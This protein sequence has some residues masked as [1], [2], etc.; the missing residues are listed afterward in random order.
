MSYESSLKGSAA[1][2]HPTRVASAREKLLTD[3]NLPD[4][5]VRSVIEASWQ[6]CVT[7]QVDP[8]VAKHSLELSSDE[9]MGIRRQHKELISASEIIMRE[10]KELLAL[11]S[12]REQHEDSFESARGLDKP[13]HT[14]VWL[15][16][17]P[18]QNEGHDN[19][20]ADGTEHEWHPLDLH[21]RKAAKDIG[22]SCVAIY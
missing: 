18:Q 1:V 22:Q 9:L 7:S 12:K 8:L 6:R 4:N 14:F 5:T 2:S 15:V 20:K 13:P 21:M 16:A 19:H 11:G 3:G 10:A 17:T